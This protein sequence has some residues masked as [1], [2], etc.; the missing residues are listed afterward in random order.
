MAFRLPVAAAKFKM[1]H[2]Q[3]QIDTA[4]QNLGEITSRNSVFIDINRMSTVKIDIYCVEC[5]IFLTRIDFCF[6]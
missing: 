6:V 5:S 4:T 2:Y 1:K 3:Y